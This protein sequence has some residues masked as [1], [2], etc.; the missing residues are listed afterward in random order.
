MSYS[1]FSHVRLAAVSAIVSQG[2]IRLEDETAY[3]GNDIRK[4][5]RSGNILAGNPAVA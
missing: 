2:E 4:I 5:R 3:Y 1:A